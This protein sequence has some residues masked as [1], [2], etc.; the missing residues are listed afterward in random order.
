MAGRRVT[1]RNSLRPVPLAGSAPAAFDEAPLLVTIYLRDRAQPR[2]RAGSR[3]DLAALLARCDRTELSAQRAA[4]LTEA[5][6]QIRSFADAHRLT[7]TNIDLACRRVQLSASTDAMERAFATRLHAHEHSGR[8][9]RFPVRQLRIPRELRQHVHAV[10]GLDERPQVARGVHAASVQGTGEGLLP[11]DV[12]RLYGLQTGGTG[13]GQCIAI[14]QPAGGYD[15]ADLAASCSAM[16]VPLPTI[17]DV[18]VGNGHNAFGQDIE[19]DKEVALDLQVAIGVAPGARF[20]VYFTADNDQGLVDAVTTA[21]HDTVN[22][23]SVLVTSWGDA[24]ENWSETARRAMD[25]ALADAA[26]LGVTVVAAVGDTLATDGLMDGRAHVDYPASSPYVLACGG[27]RITLTE[28]RSGIAQEQ[29]WNDRISGTGGGISD[30]Y[31]VPDFQS[32][33]PLPSSVNDGGRRRGVPDL[34]AAAAADP[35]YRIVVHGNRMVMGGTSAVAPLCGGFLALINERRQSPL[36]LISERLYRG[37]ALFRPVTVGD[38]RPFG[39]DIGYD[40]GAGW[41]ACAGL[42]TPIGRALVESLT[43]EAIS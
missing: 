18:A 42:G 33:T 5:A 2:R 23:P 36:G 3:A 26:S 38:N 24:E 17:V 7:V 28:D 6:D 41:S 1:L 11:S 32:G 14:V 37:P 29:V 16:N 12:A 39:S 30:F 27:T 22:R 8:Q 19:A 15:N 25:A 43:R 31:P 10:L 21:V 13:V 34:S 20:A 40:A 4:A 35:G 9:L